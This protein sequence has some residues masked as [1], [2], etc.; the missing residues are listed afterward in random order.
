MGQVLLPPVRG[1][2]YQYQTTSSFVNRITSLLRKVYGTSA[3][4][5]CQRWSLSVSNDKGT[6]SPIGGG[7]G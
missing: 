5:S 4:V 2:P 1:G 3:I 7:G 6:L